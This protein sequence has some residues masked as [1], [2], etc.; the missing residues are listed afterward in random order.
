VLINAHEYN[1]TNIDKRDVAAA[2]GTFEVD[3]DDGLIS[4]K[5]YCN[6]WFECTDFMYIKV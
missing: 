4:I 5:H 6:L 2:T 1:N 3:V